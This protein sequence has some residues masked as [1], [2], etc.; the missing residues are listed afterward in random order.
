VT[1]LDGAHVGRGCVI[2]AGTVVRGEIP[3]Y[4]VVAG[5]PGRVIKSRR[6]ETLAQLPEASSLVS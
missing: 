2:A 6:Q 1:F 4:S 5:V 3:S